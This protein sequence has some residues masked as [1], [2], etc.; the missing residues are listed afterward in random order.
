MTDEI[1][2]K[3]GFAAMS[4]EKQRELASRGGK[5]AHRLGKGHKWTKDEAREAGKRG[6]AASRGGRGKLT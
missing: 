5:A 6:G 3:R 4:P 2:K 1:K